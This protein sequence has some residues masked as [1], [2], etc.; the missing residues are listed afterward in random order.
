MEPGSTVWFQQDNFRF[1]MEDGN[2][3]H[4]LKTF[5]RQWRRRS[6]LKCSSAV[7]L[8]LPW[9]PRGKGAVGLGENS[10]TRTWMA[11]LAP[12]SCSDLILMGHDNNLSPSC[13]WQGGELVSFC[14]P[15]PGK[16]Y[17]H[18]NRASLSGLSWEMQL[19]R[20]NLS[21]AGERMCRSLAT[22]FREAL[23]ACSVDVPADQRLLDAF[24]LAQ[25]WLCMYKEWAKG[26]KNVFQACFSPHTDSLISLLHYLFCFRSLSVWVPLEELAPSVF[27]LLLLNAGGR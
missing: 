24:L 10:Q 2:S 19:W 18:Q 8:L 23:R 12:L 14:F 27:C 16:L 22:G 7:L 6:C 15:S 17:L 4:R 26:L 13:L 9:A 25:G 5:T 20:H 11:I 3:W 1:L 21:S